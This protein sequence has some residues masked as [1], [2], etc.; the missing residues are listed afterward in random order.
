VLR[1]QDAVGLAV[2]GSRV[3]V[4]V[5]PRASGEHLGTIC[6]L[7]EGNRPGGGTALG[8]VLHE[9]AERLAPRSM[10]IV[11]SDLLAP[12]EEVVAGLEHLRYNR[13]EVIVLHVLDPAELR[14]P[15][16]GNVLFE[17]LE[18]PQRLMLE[19]PRVRDAYLEAL[20]RFRAGLRQAC[21]RLRVDYCPADTSERV[22][23]PLRR[24]LV[25]RR[26]L[27]GVLRG[28]TV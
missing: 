9:L 6:R 8:S 4:E 21:G 20:H 10:V 19:A 27:A 16:R 5:P 17:A 14:F 22:D 24:L 2:F 28:W 26:S 12:L 15:F 3:R 11:V 18:S 1:Q 25:S 7:M 23:R 13:H